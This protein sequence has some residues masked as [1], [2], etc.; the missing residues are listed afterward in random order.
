MISSA[1]SR[2]RFDNE[3]E[4]SAGQLL[5]RVLGRGCAPGLGG[6]Q[7]GRSNTA[8]GTVTDKA[9]CCLEGGQ[10]VRYGQARR[11]NTQGGK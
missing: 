7:R 11:A 2:L 1:A 4:S 10:E 6:C 8:Q 9:L 3:R 5:G